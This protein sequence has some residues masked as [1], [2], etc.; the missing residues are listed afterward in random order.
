[1]LALL[2]LHP[3]R[4]L[5]VREIARLT[6]TTAGTLNKELARLHE[7]KL[8]ERER[9]GNR[10][11]CWADQEHQIYAE[12]SSILAKIVGLADVLVEALAPLA[13]NIDVPL[14]FGSISRGTATRGS[15]VDVLIVGSLDFGSV[16]DALYPAQ[17]RLGQE[18]D[19]KVYAK[20]EYSA[21]VAAKDAFLAKLLS[22]PKIFL[23]GNEYELGKLGRSRPR[24]RDAVTADDKAPSRRRRAPDP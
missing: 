23:I 3:E 15:D 20:G 6:G 5:H 1:M 7:A 14:L 8:L 21:K 9:V 24:G 2:L 19:P 18:I 10:L 22:Q 4:N 11:F 12:L 17:Q 16:V 13:P